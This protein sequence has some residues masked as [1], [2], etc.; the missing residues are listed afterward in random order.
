MPRALSN[1]GHLRE[2]IC[3]VA[4]SGIARRDV[5][6][7]VIESSLPTPTA[8]NGTN[9]MPTDRTGSGSYSL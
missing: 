1:S 2:G 8:T 3:N 7:V 9:F 4:I 5:G 6:V